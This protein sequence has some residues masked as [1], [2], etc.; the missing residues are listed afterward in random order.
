VV[1]LLIELEDMESEGLH[2]MI[3]EILYIIHAI[4]FKNPAFIG[5]NNTNYKK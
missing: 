3:S 5:K 2:M 1:F 4:K